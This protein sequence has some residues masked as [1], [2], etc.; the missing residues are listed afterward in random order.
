MIDEMRFLYRNRKDI[1]P[2]E[3]FRAATASGAAALNYGGVLGRLRRGYWAD[4]TV[5]ELPQN[6][7]PRDLLHQVLEGA[8]ACIATVI[9]GKIVFSPASVFSQ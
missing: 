2:E 3:I 6:L 7:A 5:L 8:G 1:T 4:M 9:K